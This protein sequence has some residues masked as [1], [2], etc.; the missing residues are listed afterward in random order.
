MHARAKRNR[1][2]RERAWRE[3]Y[4]L[5][6]LSVIMGNVR[7]AN[8]KMDELETLIRSQ[9]TYRENSLMCF[10]ETWLKDCTLESNTSISSFLM[11]WADRD[12]KTSGK[13]KGGVLLCSSTTDGVTLDMLRSLNRSVTRTLNS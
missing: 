3:T 4:K 11:I 13:R 8:N 1:R 2:Q 10:S 12:T 5:A 6:L 9:R 7:Y